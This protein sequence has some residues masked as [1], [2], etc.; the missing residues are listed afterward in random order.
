LRLEGL[1]V[2]ALSILLYA[3]TG[4][5]WWMF[6][7][8]W[9]VPDLSILGYLAGSRIGANC[10]NAVHSY[11]APVVLATVAL[12]HPSAILEPITLIWFNHIGV[13]RMLGYGLKYHS[14]FGDTH[15]KR[16]G[17]K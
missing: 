3:R 17:K 15:L 4:A 16:L 12:L 7:A 10:Y 5:S 9:L 6:A 2:A 14:G 13:D 1:A 11:L 8:L